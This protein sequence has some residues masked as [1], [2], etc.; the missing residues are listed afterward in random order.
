MLK[1]SQEKPTPHSPLDQ[2][3]NKAR[4][5]RTTGH[6]NRITTTHISMVR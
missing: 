4:T 2:N 6:K 1:N 5:T 3:S